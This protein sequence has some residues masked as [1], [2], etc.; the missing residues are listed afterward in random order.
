M[1]PSDLS[2][3][4]FEEYRKVFGAKQL[5]S[6]QIIQIVTQLVVGTRE[7]ERKELMEIRERLQA[8]EAVL[9]DPPQPTSIRIVNSFD[10]RTMIRHEQEAAFEKKLAV[11]TGRENE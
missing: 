7:Q 11:V 5:T 3:L 10:S 6:E 4:V 2:T 1:S 8:V 9:A